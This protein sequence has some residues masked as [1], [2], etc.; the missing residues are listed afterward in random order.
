MA[1]S[2]R[3]RVRA[4]YTRSDGTNQVHL[5]VIINGKP[6]WLPLELHWPAKFF[7]QA[8]GLALPQ[9]TRDKK[10]QAAADDVNLQAGQVLSRVNDIFVRWR[11]S[12]QELTMDEFL[13]EFN[14]KLSKTNFCDYFAT[15]LDER[16]RTEEI[17]ELSYKAQRATLRK[18]QEFNTLLPFVNLRGMDFARKF[19]LFLEKKKKS[20]ANTR[21]SRH[22]DVKTY[23]NLA[24]DK[25]NI[26]FEDPYKDF[27][28]AK[29][30]G[31]WVAALPREIE[32]LDTYYNTL[33]P[34]ST[35]RRYLRRWLFGVATGL[36]LSDQRE[37]RRDWLYESTL[38]FLM[39]KG[40]RKKAE[41]MLPIGRRALELWHDALNERD[42]DNGRTFINVTGQQSNDM[43][44]TIRQELGIRS[45]LH[46]HVGRESFATLYLE[47]GGS[48][49]VL[50]EYL[51]HSF[52][53]TTMKYVHVSAARK[54]RDLVHVDSIFERRQAPV[55]P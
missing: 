9:R 13:K 30:K 32:L 12:G 46:N 25:D 19:D 48:L 38:I 39:Q 28:V 17:G 52:I 53:D 34:G 54:R 49:E 15:K 43:M 11:L 23:L 29:V 5:Q 22:K 36:R 6:K 14:N 24:A 50:R 16:H 44:E 33:S 37:A 2:A 40:R 8:A 7:D 10:A 18:L 3:V 51:G 27:K 42:G 4:S 55:Q 45:N 47:N 35:R 31:K 26:R 21:W 20:S 41:M 1:C